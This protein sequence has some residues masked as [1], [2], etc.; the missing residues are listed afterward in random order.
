MSITSVI[1]TVFVFVVNF[2]IQ[3]CY[4]AD[5]LF[6]LSVGMIVFNIC[7]NLAMGVG[8]SVVSVGGFLK[9]QRDWSGFRHVVVRSIKVT[10]LIGFAVSI[11]VMS[12]VRLLAQTFGADTTEIVTYCSN[13]LRIFIWIVP[14]SMLVTLMMFIYQAMM[15]LRLIPVPTIAFS[16]T[17]IAVLLAWPYVMPSETLW[18]AFPLSALLSI[19]IIYLISEIVRNGNN[20]V[21]RFIQIPKHTDD[22]DVEQLQLSI[23]C[24]KDDMYLSLK[25]IRAFIDRQNISDGLE[26]KLVLC[27]EEIFLN[28]NE[29]AGLIGGGHCY[30][31]IIRMERDGIL[32]VVKD[33]GR[34]FNP[35]AVGEEKR[36]LGLDILLGICKHVD[37]QHMYGQNL[38]VLQFPYE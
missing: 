32:S 10:L 13:A 28:I 1:S 8:R 15:N 9:G 30:D 31:V 35:L 29:Y 7:V 6:A 3:K 4:G 23:P 36:G 27:L 22:E 26:G 24:N 12:G 17:E 5:G 34:P 18:Y 2:S 25:S 11:A 33:D 16:V 21:Y 20:T 38:L 37:Y 14:S 19:G